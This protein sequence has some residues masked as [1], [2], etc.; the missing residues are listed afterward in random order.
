M[1]KHPTMPSGGAIRVEFDQL[2]K[3]IDRIL[4]RWTND[5]RPT[6]LSLLN[7][8]S[9]AIRSGADWGAL[10]AAASTQ[11]LTVNGKTHVGLIPPVAK[12]AVDLPA[13]LCAINIGENDLRLAELTADVK[14][15]FS[16]THGNDPIIGLELSLTDGNGFCDVSIYNRLI[17]FR[18]GAAYAKSV[19]AYDLAPDAARLIYCAIQNLQSTELYPVF[20]Q[21][22]CGRLRILLGPTQCVLSLPE[23]YSRGA[24]ASIPSQGLRV[25]FDEGDAPSAV[26]IDISLRLA[27]VALPHLD[28]E[29][30]PMDKPVQFRLSEPLTQIWEPIDFEY[31]SHLDERAMFRELGTEDWMHYDDFLLDERIDL[32]GTLGEPLDLA[33]ALVDIDDP[34][35]YLKVS[36]TSG[37]KNGR[38]R[39]PGWRGGF[40][41]DWEVLRLRAGRP[42]E[43]LSLD[44]ETRKRL[45]AGLNGWAVHEGYSMTND[46]SLVKAEALIARD[47]RRASHHMNQVEAIMD[48]ADPTNEALMKSLESTSF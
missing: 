15:L 32:N 17:L 13:R 21:S 30:F 36:L 18:D 48:G 34:D 11:S 7:D 43:I 27:S 29:Q 33:L 20:A 39:K 6:K 31:S 46:L 41:A 8:L 35:V 12:P 23:V 47:L 42:A 25:L 28:L 16:L 19:H 2:S 1:K 37:P 5:N 38:S 40:H 44:D 24:P 3:G 4:D 9:A 22:D 14:P 10:K 26:D 45:E